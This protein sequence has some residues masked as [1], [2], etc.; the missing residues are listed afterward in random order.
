MLLLLL[1]GAAGGAYYYWEVL[2]GMPLYQEVE[3]NDETHQ[4]NLLRPKHPIRGYIGRRLKADR[5]DRDFYKIEIPA[6]QDLVNVR[7]SGVPTLDLV[8]DGYTYGGKRLA[9]GDAGRAGEGEGLALSVGKERRILVAVREVWVKG[10]APLE[11]STDAYTLEVNF[12][13]TKAV[14]EP[15]HPAIDGSVPSPKP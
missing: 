9:K 1:I 4:A 6:G 11:N 14:I 13:A 15:V 3:P 8:L 12:S 7:L 10:V 2:G 5:S